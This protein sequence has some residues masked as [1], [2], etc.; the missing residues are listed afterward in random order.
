M[1]LKDTFFGESIN[2]DTGTLIYHHLQKIK[3]VTL[4]SQISLISLIFTEKVLTE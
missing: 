4:L 3:Y 2:Y 1:L